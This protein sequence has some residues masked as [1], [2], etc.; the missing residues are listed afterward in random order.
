MSSVSRSL[1][2]AADLPAVIFFAALA[3]VWGWL[4]FVLTGEW[5]ANEQYSH[6][7][8]IP[9]LAGWIF[10]QRWTCRPEPKP[11]TGAFRLAS[12][13]VLALLVL[14]A[15]FGILIAGAYPDWRVVLWGL[16][17]AAFVASVALTALAGGWPWVRQLSFAFVFAL[18][19]IPWPTGPERWLTQELSL[20]AADVAGW[21]LP[22]LG[23]AAQSH[24]T[25][26]DVG[27]EV[28]GVDDACSGIR[29]FQSSLMAALFLGELFTLRWGY[30]LLLCV[31]GL[32]AAY[33]LNVARMLI[34]SIAVANEGIGAL[35]K[36]HDPAGF[37]ILIVTMAFL[38]LLCWGAQKI[39]GSTQPAAV[40]AKDA[41]RLGP[42][43]VR[44]AGAV[45]LAV[46]LM[47]AGSEAWYWW[48]ARDLVRA[49]V[50]TIAAADSSTGLQDEPLDEKAEEM[51]RYDVGFQRA[52]QDADGRFWHLI[53]VE[54]EPKRMSL[55]YAQPHLPEQCQRMLG[56]T[57]VSKSE[58]RRT[59][60]NGV[61]IVY[62]LYKIRAGADEFYLM[63][64]V[65]DDRIGGEQIEVKRATP[66][67][68]LN[69]VL[70][71]RRNMG[72]RSLQL[73]L[74]GEA[75]EAEAEKA[76]RALLPQ[77][78]QPAP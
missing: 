7:W 22:L 30:R 13:A 39:P 36:L 68:R 65:S 27:A 51:L 69:A 25:S 47:A 12:Y 37:A 55:H 23:V 43:A 19:A 62:N 32:I 70:A 50:W 42:A 56:R 6:G 53:F 60:A 4:F 45:A 28:L 64:V 58:L 72:Q 1:F 46:A 20:L 11:A 3:A 49:P 66:A 33:A 40:P 18:V 5:D 71:G 17:G 16:G 44:T 34:L 76:M 29:S 61:G 35:D 26:I 52:W 9:L 31:L 57:I 10:W 8:F 41:T 24:G 48:K 14:P 21:M 73:A 75:D 74:V 78:V 2:P 67:N 63:Y 54:W 77:L 15:A 38:W 59:E